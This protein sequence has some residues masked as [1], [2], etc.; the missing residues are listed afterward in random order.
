E[1]AAREGSP[2]RRN[3]RGAAQANRR[4]RLWRFSRTWQRP[5]PHAMNAHDVAVFRARP[6]IRAGWAAR[7]RARAIAVEVDQN[8]EQ[9]V[10]YLGVM[11]VMKQMFGAQ[12]PQQRRGGALA[13]P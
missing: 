7:Q 4:R 11:N 3:C 8:R 13:G 2:N 6:H 5:L 1:S 9:P 12:R 10:P